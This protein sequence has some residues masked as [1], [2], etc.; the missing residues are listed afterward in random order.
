[1]VLKWLFHK[2]KVKILDRKE[3]LKR[4]MSTRKSTSF[5]YTWTVMNNKQNPKLSNFVEAAGLDLT[6]NT[7][8]GVG[9]I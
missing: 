4:V 8:F 9:F 6:V 7:V 5:P 1:M 2:K 3:Q